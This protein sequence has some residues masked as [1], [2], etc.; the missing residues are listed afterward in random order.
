[1]RDD[2]NP[3]AIGWTVD[4]AAMA[5]MRRWLV[6]RGFVVVRDEYDP[7]SFGNQE[8]ILTRPVAI[9]LVRD[10]GEWR[11]ELMGSDGQWAGIL[12]WRDALRGKGSFL[13]TAADQADLVREMLDEVERG[14]SAT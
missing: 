3:P 5:D 10:R 7:D 14:V 12:Q 11:T 9:R 1:M 2:P 4:D 13:A 8:V 6:E